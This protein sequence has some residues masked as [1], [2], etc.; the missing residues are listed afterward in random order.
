MTPYINQGKNK[1]A[2]LK[3]KKKPKT[4]V[5]A[6]K[7]IED[8]SAGSKLY[9]FNT[10]GIRNPKVLATIIFPIIARNIMIPIIGFPTLK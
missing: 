1:L 6:V 5:A 7:K 9:F 2:K 3:K 10:N 8:P 4:S